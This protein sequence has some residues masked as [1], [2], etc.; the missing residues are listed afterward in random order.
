MINQKLKQKI[1]EKRLKD[2]VTQGNFDI[3][4]IDKDITSVGL[5]LGDSKFLQH[6]GFK[7]KEQIQM[8]DYLQDNPK[9]VKRLFKGVI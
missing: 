9:L 8:L 4:T 1:N 5:K 3:H 2:F 7:R 6:Q